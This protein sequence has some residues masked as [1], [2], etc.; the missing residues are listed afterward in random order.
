MSSATNCF[1]DGPGAQEIMGRNFGNRKQAIEVCSS[2]PL[3]GCLVGTLFH[4]FTAYDST[5]ATATV[6]SDTSLLTDEVN[7]HQAAACNRAAQK[8]FRQVQHIPGA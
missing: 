5:S 8:H 6:T 4:L 2:I 7:D 3:L 1:G